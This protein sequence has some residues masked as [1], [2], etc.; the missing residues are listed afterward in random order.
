PRAQKL[1]LLAFEKR[2]DAVELLAEAQPGDGLPLPTHWHAAV[3]RF[4][5]SAFAMRA[6]GE[7]FHRVY[8]LLKRQEIELLRARV[9]DVEFEVYLRAL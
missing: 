9:T 2:I 6:L 7:E 5:Q 3:E 4:E 1:D 8:A